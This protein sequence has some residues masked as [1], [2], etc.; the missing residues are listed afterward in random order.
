RSSKLRARALPLFLNYYN[1][2]RPHGSLGGRPP[3]SRLKAR[4]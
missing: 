3:S 1:Q 4:V 2:E